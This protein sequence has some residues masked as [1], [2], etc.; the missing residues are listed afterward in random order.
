MDA[1]SG[2]W[3]GGV[4]VFRKTNEAAGEKRYDSGPSRKKTRETSASPYEGIKSALQRSEVSEGETS[5]SEKGKN[6]SL[7]RGRSDHLLANG[8]ER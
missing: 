3:G 4:L 6:D 8:T 7:P 5:S 1:I 2:F